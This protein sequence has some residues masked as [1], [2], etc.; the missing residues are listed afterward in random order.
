MSAIKQ[1][2]PHAVDP[3]AQLR[4]SRDRLAQLQREEAEIAGHIRVAILAEDGGRVS[5]L[6]ARQRMLPTLIAAAA[7]ALRPLELAT[8]DGL[9]AERAHHDT[10]LRLDEAREAAREAQREADRAYQRAVVTFESF[11]GQ[12]DELARQRRAV[13]ERLT[14]LAASDAPI[15]AA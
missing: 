8:L 7:I 1:T 6:T 3:A 10:V 15:T 12:R 9:L 11:R 4:A 13:D 14:A 2:K 5:A